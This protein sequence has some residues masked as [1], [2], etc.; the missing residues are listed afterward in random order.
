MQDNPIHLAAKQA[1]DV[2]QTTLPT[3]TKQQINI[4]QQASQLWQYQ[5]YHQTSI[6]QLAESCGL[7]AGELLHHIHSKPT[8]LAYVFDSL[9]RRY[10]KQLFAIAEQ[11]NIS[12]QVRR[13]RFYQALHGLLTKE[14]SLLV[15]I[16][17][18]L[19]LAEQSFT[20]QHCPSLNVHV[21]LRQF[22]KRFHHAI[23]QVLLPFF[24]RGIAEAIVEESMYHIIG[25]LTMQTL[26]QDHHYSHTLCACLKYLWY[27]QP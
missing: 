3:L 25:L 14:H 12:D 18:G 27:G 1:K 17:L 6:H 23:M 2:D 11:L 20:C 9:Q 19:E 26:T 22:L 15:M 4:V 24:T 10:Q 13:D 8:L 16:R 5:G 21:C 7:T